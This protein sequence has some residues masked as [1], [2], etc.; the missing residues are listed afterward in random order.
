VFIGMPFCCRLGICME[1]ED[2]HGWVVGL[3]GR[4]RG[5][6]FFRSGVKIGINFF[7]P[8]GKNR[9]QF[10]PLSRQF[11]SSGVKIETQPP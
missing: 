9:Q 4:G 8:G 3:W 7:R 2:V 10:F 6:N 1:G 11:F 5:F